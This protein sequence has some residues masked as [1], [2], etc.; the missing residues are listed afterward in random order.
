MTL[1][2]YILIALAIVTIEI[3]YDKWCWR[4]VP[5]KNDKPESTILRG[6]LIAIG[7][8][9][10][11]LVTND[12]NLTL[13]AVAVI[14]STLFFTFDFALNVS[15][16]K[17]LPTPRY[18]YYQKRFVR[19]KKSGYSEDQARRMSYSALTDWETIVYNITIFIGRFF[20]HGDRYTK[21]WYDLFFQRFAPPPM[22][23]LLKLIGLWAG[24][25]WYFN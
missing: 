19:Y 12:I 18:V 9:I 23:V 5:W 10:T 2:I 15:R 8:I 3:I 21:S 25:Y 24:L 4:Q 16:W 6:S 7:G 13:R 17:D 1:S 22:E 14:L 11:Y 20:W